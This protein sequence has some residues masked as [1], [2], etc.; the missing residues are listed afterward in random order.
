MVGTTGS[1]VKARQRAREQRLAK[2]RE[3]RL[4]LDPERL[5]REERIDETT[6]DVE[7]ARERLSEA[8]DAVDAAER[9][10]AVGLGRLVAEKLTVGEVAELTGLDERTV[11]RLRRL[12]SR[13]E[14]VATE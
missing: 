8:Q 9:S 5:A 1:A 11:R 7:E 10:I 13:S 12:K 14:P 2:A 3:R 6:A 4:R